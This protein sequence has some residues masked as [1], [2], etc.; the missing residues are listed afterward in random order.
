VYL[1]VID[2]QAHFNEFIN[3]L[4]NVFIFIYVYIEE[5][6]EVLDYVICPLLLGDE[7]D[8]HGVT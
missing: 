1:P 8:V 4:T 3:L 2:G 6:T 5:G 7:V